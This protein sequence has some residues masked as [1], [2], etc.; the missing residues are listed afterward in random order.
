MAP[1]PTLTPWL[2][3]TS[4]NAV[5]FSRNCLV[6]SFSIICNLSTPRSLCFLSSL[7][8]LCVSGAARSQ[9]TSSP[10]HRDGGNSST[11]SFSEITCTKKSYE[12]SYFQPPLKSKSWCTDGLR[13]VIL[14]ICINRAVTR[15]RH[16]K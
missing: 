4:L 12:S 5:L 3:K 6:C 13:N 11:A 10:G 9:G 7:Q 14:N 2:V 8:S 16:I 1:T 15:I